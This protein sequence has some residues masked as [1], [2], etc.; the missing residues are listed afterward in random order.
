[1][2]RNKEKESRICG[3]GGKA[4]R[5]QLATKVARKSAPAIGGV[6]KLHKF[7][8]GT[9]A[10]REIR[11]YQKSTELLIRKFLFQRLFREI[12]QD[13]KTYLRFQSSSI[14]ALQEASEVYS[15][16]LF[17]DTNLCA[18]HAKRVTIMPKDMQLAM[19]IRVLTGPQAQATQQVTGPNP[20]G[21]E[22]AR[23]QDTDRSARSNL[24]M[25]ARSI[26][27]AAP[28][29]LVE[30]TPLYDKVTQE[31]N[32]DLSSYATKG[33]SIIDVDLTTT[34]LLP[35]GESS[36]RKTSGPTNAP[37]LQQKLTLKLIDTVLGVRIMRRKEEAQEEKTKPSHNVRRDTSLIDCERILQ[38]KEKEKETYTRGWDQTTH[39]D[40][41]M[42]MEKGVPAGQQKPQA[43]EGRT[44]GNS[45]E[46]TLRV[47][48]NVS[49]KSKK[50]GTPPTAEAA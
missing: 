10:L 35:I 3:R 6:K 13:F 29:A 47:L 27:S 37:D 50:H 14:A 45:F 1:M 9:V 31:D 25:A 5:K 46:A 7:R 40:T 23:H 34:T 15:V 43:K 33:G 11:K 41:G 2:K 28:H 39:H 30:H 26:S 24:H 8:P 38:A 20:K 44:L 16:G 48:A 17:E 36:P 49:K 32:D 21:F 12:A 42:Q 22:T 4:P 18:I 19:R